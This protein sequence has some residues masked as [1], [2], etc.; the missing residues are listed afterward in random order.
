MKSIS[1]MTFVAGVALSALTGSAFAAGDPAAGEK[2]FAKCKACHQV[3]ETA[4]N[5]IAPELNGIDG[6]AAG[7]A[8]GYNYSDAMKGSGITWN[9][10]SFKEF[11]KNPKAKVPGTKMVF[12]GL[13]TEKDEDDVWAYLSGFGADG[14]KK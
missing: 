5:A 4:K 6:R 9:E 12:Q 3:G 13:P 10:A 8:A 1:L 7:T 11:I 14:K 2:V